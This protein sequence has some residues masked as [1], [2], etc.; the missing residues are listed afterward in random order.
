MVKPVDLTSQ[1]FGRLVVERAGTDGQ[2]PTWLCRCDCGNTTITKGMYLRRRDTQSCGCLHQ[3][4]FTNKKHGGKRSLLY[5]IWRN[6]KSG[7]TIRSIFLSKITVVAALP[8]APNGFMT[9]RLSVIGPYPTA[10][11]TI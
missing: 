3:E 2:Y 10:T 7:A 8:S 5:S 1:R 4:T 11:G 9:L 6:M